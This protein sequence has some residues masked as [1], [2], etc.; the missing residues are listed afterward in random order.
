MKKG[1]VS[2]QMRASIEDPHR[3]R[4]KNETENEE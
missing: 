3:E 2:V 4:K 1:V